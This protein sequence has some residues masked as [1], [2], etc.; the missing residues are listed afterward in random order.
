MASGIAADAAPAVPYA[1][2]NVA[3]GGGGFAPGIVFSTVE[4]DLAY[5]RTDMGG[6]YRWDSRAGRWI[7]LEDG[8]AEGSY[9]GIESVAADPRDANVV[10]LAAGVGA[11]ARAAILRSADRGAH[12]AITPVPFA[13]G[14]N[15]DG[16]GLGER[17]AI[18]PF[19]TASLWFGSRHDGLWHS[20]D[21]GAHWRKVARFPLGGLGA[22]TTRRATHGGLSFV[23]FDPARAGRIFVASADPGAQHLFHSDDGGAHWQAVAGGPEPGLLPVKAVI[24]S[25]GVLTIT[26]SDAIGPNGITLQSTHVQ[27]QAGT[28][29]I[30]NAGGQTKINGSGSLTLNGKTTQINPDGLGD[31]AFGASINFGPP[32]GEG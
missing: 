4:R 30:I 15:E 14:G 26:Y 3:V 32:A 6:A 16:R 12:W 31:G 1:W 9:M 28:E 10:Y 27:I 17:L 7:P 20:D 13:M 5:L 21:R 19:D 8:I 29:A 22:P 11:R 18:D 25:D 24:G 23:L 2:R